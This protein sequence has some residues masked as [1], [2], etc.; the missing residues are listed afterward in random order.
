[1]LNPVV[2]YSN[3]APSLAYLRFKPRFSSSGVDVECRRKERGHKAIL[4]L[5]F[6]L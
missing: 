3:I 2:R 5:L 4:L 1:M 6:I